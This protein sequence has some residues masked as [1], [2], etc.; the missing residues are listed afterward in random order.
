MTPWRFQIK[1]R[2]ASRKRPAVCSRSVLVIGGINFG[3]AVSEIPTICAENHT[4]LISFFVTSISKGTSSKM[5]KD[6]TDICITSYV[7]EVDA[8]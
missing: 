2:R 8:F 7:N 4:E 1:R 3:L 6:I 5:T